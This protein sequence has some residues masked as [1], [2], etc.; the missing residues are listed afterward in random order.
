LFIFTEEM[1]V[2]SVTEEVQ[3]EMFDAKIKDIIS[4]FIYHPFVT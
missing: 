2:N 1:F 3:K 4:I